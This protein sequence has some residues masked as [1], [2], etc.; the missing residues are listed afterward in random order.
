MQEGPTSVEE[1]LMEFLSIEE[2]YGSPGVATIFSIKI[3]PGGP[4]PGRRTSR[5]EGE[6]AAGGGGEGG[7]ERE[8]VRGRA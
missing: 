5:V 7:R 8:G 6:D 3:C 1:E 4:C 2:G